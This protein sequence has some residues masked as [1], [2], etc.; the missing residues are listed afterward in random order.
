MYEEGFKKFYWGFLL[1][2]IDF[3]LQGIDIFPDIIGFIFFANGIKLL[4]EQSS[5]FNKAL[6]Y[7]YFMI[8]LSIFSI[9]DA[10]NNSG[11]LNIQFVSWGPFVILVSIA[12]V[13]LTLLAVYNI[14]MGIKDM[15]QKEELSDISE[16]ASNRWSQFLYLQIASIFSFIL[17]LIPF[18]AIIYIIVLFII[19][20][21]YTIN[22]LEFMKHCQETL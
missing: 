19:S 22:V 4:M 3:R 21:I 5:F 12:S 13:I 14:F 6:P 8:V 7:N 11:G 15:G 1:V 9:Y 17:I 16:E 18:L 20:I 2:L 10:P